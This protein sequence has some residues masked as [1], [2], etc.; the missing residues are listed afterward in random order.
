MI[1]N[2][3]T[4]GIPSLIPLSTLVLD[5]VQDM[6]CDGGDVRDGDQD[7]DDDHDE[8]DYDDDP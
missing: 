3:K 4:L 7:D 6:V 8:P 2:H 5:V 1:L